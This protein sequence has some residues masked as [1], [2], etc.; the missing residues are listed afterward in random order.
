MKDQF[1]II[2]DYT[3][4]HTQELREIYLQ[5][6][7]F[8]FPWI[9]PDNFQLLDFDAVTIDECMLVAVS[10]N[11]PVGFIAW[12]PPDHFIH[13]LFVN[14]AFTG[15]GIGKSLLN[16]CLAKIAR[17]A[18]LKCLKENHRALNFYN[19]Q[20]WTIISDGES[21]DGDYFLLSFE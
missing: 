19:S 10:E 15:K 12:W 5:A 13:S 18:T 4:Q 2:L 8:A 7:K 9:N 21:E 16:A 1:P 14:P 20:G 11:I 3:P 6:R 17:P